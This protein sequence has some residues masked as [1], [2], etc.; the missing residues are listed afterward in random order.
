MRNSICSALLAATALLAAAPELYPIR[1]GRKIGFIDGSGNIVVEPKFDAAGEFSDG[2]VR[3]SVGSASGYLDANGRMAVEPRYYV[4]NDFSG[5]RAIVAAEDGKYQLI[6]RSGRVIAAIPYRVLGTFHQGLCRMQRPRIGSSPVAYGYFDRDGRTVIEPQF[7][8]AGD[9]SDGEDAL[10]IA[11]KDRQYHFIDR[12]GRTMLTLPIEGHDRASRFSEGLVPW[13]QDGWWGYRDARGNW[14][15][16]PQ[17]D[18]ADPFENGL[19]RVAVAKGKTQWIDRKGDKQDPPKFWREK[20]FAE[21]FAVMRDNGRLGYMNESG[22]SAFNLPALEAAHSFSNGLA[23]VKMDG[24]YGYIDRKGN[25][26]LKPQFREASDFRGRLAR[27]SFPEGNWGY[28][29]STG[30][31]VWESPKSVQL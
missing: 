14:V 21:G 3:V 25:W 22:K 4:A 10:A 15:I 27:V 1:D 19:A 8:N 12:T 13:K 2:L 7:I 24:L 28:I 5:G 9:F 20:P 31:R 30:K 18:A 23:R 17:Y 16:R 26:A 6:D 11:I 29:D